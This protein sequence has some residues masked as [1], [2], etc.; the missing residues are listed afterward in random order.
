MP[1][2]ATTSPI[3]DNTRSGCYIAYIL[4][5]VVADLSINLKTDLKRRD[6]RVFAFVRTGT[7]A[8]ARLFLPTWMSISIV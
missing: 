5:A 2:K 8:T 7:L 3:K 6:S 4:N 1:M